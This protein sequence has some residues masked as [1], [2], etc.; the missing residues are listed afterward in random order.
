MVFSGCLPAS[1][2]AQ[3][4]LRGG[5]QAPPGRI[6]A[7]EPAGVVLGAPDPGAVGPPAAPG[8]IPA[9]PL[10][11]VAARPLVVIGWDRIRRVEGE[12][13]EPAAEFRDVADAAWRARTRLE[14]GDALAA[15]QLF[16]QLFEK[17]RGQQGPTAAVVAE[18]LL[19]CQLR[20]G[21]HVAAIQPWLALL[22]ARTAAPAHAPDWAVQA[23]LPPVF[24]DNTGLVPGLPPIWL[25]WPAVEAFARSGAATGETEGVLSGRGEALAALYLYAARVETGVYAPMP[26]IRSTDPGVQLVLTIVQS[27]GGDAEQRQRARQR[28]EDRL[29]APAANAPPTPVWVEVWCRA[30]IGRSLLRESTVEA[31]RQGVLELLHLPAR[32]AGSNPYLAGLALAESAVAL[33]EMGDHRSADIL[34]RELADQFPTHPVHDWDPLRRRA[35]PQA[36][37]PADG[38][39]SSPSERR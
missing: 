38:A 14:R 33:R 2:A 9:Q 37:P 25:A 23:G 20:R 31:R 16:E 32:F 4:E 27:R 21:A 17:Y 3:L 24:D 19:R 10:S 12:F 18:G 11:P 29:R 35:R 28:L 6:I 39:T 36:V 34:V 13:A 5:E 30:A 1:L 22:Q 26:N 8:A 7:V 15:E